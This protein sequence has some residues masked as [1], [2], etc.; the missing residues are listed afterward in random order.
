MLSFLSLIYS[1]AFFDR[2]SQRSD[3]K[4]GGEMLTI[5]LRTLGT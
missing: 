1:H 4:G 3:S 5:E 2:V